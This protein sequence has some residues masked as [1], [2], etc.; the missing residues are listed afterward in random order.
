LGITISDDDDDDDPSNTVTGGKD[1][2]RK[3]RISFSL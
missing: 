3:S 2:L 1:R